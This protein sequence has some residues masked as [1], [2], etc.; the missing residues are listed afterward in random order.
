MTIRTTILGLLFV[1]SL[2]LGMKALSTHPCCSLNCSTT[3][4]MMFLQPLP[5][6]V[7]PARGTDRLRGLGRLRPDKNNSK[8]EGRNSFATE[9]PMPTDRVEDIMAV[10]KDIDPELAAQLASLCENDPDALQKI[11]RRQGRRLGSL[12]HLRESDPELYKVKV[13]ELKTDAEIYHIA[14]E[15]RG[16]D[17]D[18]KKTQATI[19]ELE[20]LVRA[21]TKMFLQAQAL[22]IS[23]LERHLDGLRQRLEDASTRVEE[24][25]QRRMSQLLQVV[26]EEKQEQPSQIE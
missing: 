20:G 8:G 16:Q 7:T 6:E 12:I 21:K 25:V 15:L 23:R 9:R 1:L 18:A 4:L 2:M 5:D 19:A 24:I 11:I 17:F 3:C 22:N 10:A 26:G 13:T 14:Q